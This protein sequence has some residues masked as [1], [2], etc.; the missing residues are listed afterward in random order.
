MS[1]SVA[2]KVVDVLALLAV[3][4]DSDCLSAPTSNSHSSSTYEY[5]KGLGHR[6]DASSICHMSFASTQG[7][8]SERRVQAAK[9]GRRAFV[10]DR[11]KLY[12]STFYHSNRFEPFI[13]TLISPQGSLRHQMSR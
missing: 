5:E 4:T 9:F 2:G 7:W 11:V 8:L 10:V 13:A 6:G 1:A 3:P 12:P